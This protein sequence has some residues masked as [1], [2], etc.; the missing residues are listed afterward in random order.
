MFIDLWGANID[1]TRRG[2]CLV[3]KAAMSAAQTEEWIRNAMKQY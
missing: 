2:K 3:A 1:Y